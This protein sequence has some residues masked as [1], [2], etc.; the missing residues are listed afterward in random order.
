MASRPRN[1]GAGNALSLDRVAMPC[2][3]N[4]LRSFLG[5]R[6]HRR[7]RAATARAAVFKTV[8]WPTMAPNAFSMAAGIFDYNNDCWSPSDPAG[9]AG[10]L[11]ISE[12]ESNG[13]AGQGAIWQA[14]AACARR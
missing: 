13:F 12:H 14:A 10:Y 7:H 3:Q 6:G 5:L 1:E 8:L 4:C 11:R 2:G 9:D